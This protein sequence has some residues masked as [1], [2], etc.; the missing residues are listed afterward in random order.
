M[1]TLKKTKAEMLAIFLTGLFCLYGFLNLLLLC[2]TPSDLPIG[3]Y[4]SVFQRYLDLMDGKIDLA[5][6]TFLKHVDHNHSL[7]YL[8][9]L[10]DINLFGG[11]LFLL[12]AISILSH[13]GALLLV[14]H[15]LS[16]LSA[17]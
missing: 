11:R 2:G 7:V 10:A 9:G 13:L 3:D 5:D 12:Y 1:E 4:R 6:Y 15:V 16:G 14:I 8:A 17:F